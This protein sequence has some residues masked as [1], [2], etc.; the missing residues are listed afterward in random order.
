M[1]TSVTF[2][3]FPEMMVVSFKGMGLVV[4]TH[5]VGFGTTNQISRAFHQGPAMV[6]SQAKVR[7]DPIGA[8]M[9]DYLCHDLVGASKSTCTSPQKSPLPTS[10]GAR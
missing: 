9:G 8:I 4:L 2:L 7:A 10:L 1:Y 6:G 5:M 3:E